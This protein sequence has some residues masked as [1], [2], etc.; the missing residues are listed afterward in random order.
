MPAPRTELPPPA[1]LPPAGGDGPLRPHTRSCFGC[2]PQNPAG[3]GLKFVRTGDVVRAEFRLEPKHE[4]APGLAHGGVVAAVLDDLSGAV[5][6]VMRE[7][8]VTAKLEVDYVAPV[9][10]GRELTAESWLESHEGR[11]IR[12]AARVLEGD[13]LLATSRGL[14]ITVPLEHFLPREDAGP[15]VGA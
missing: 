7:R 15:T 1:P 8:C 9:V 6:V 14:F 4:G 11:K 13:Q 2:G 3:V 5:P 12:I 10:I